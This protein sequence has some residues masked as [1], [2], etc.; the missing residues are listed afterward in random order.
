MEGLEKLH[1]EEKEFKRRQSLE[2]KKQII[3]RSLKTLAK[4]AKEDSK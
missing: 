2:N 1:L 4:K 3:S